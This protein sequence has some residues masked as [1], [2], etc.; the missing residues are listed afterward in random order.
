LICEGS[1][2]LLIEIQFF[3]EKDRPQRFD[4]IFKFFRLRTC[5]FQNFTT[6]PSISSRSSFHMVRDSRRFYDESLQES[7]GDVRVDGYGAGPDTSVVNAGFIGDSRQG[8][9]CRDEEETCSDA[10]PPLPNIRL[11]VPHLNMSYTTSALS[12]P[13]RQTG[14]GVSVGNFRVAT[15][16]RQCLKHEHF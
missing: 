15:S 6:N 8:V 9:V 5:Y 4:V 7:L 16:I 13:C 3:I 11:L 14:L 10:H 12:T 1:F 2:Q